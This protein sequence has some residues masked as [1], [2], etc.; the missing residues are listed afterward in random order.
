M[1]EYRGKTPLM[2]KRNWIWILT[3]LILL[4]LVACSKKQAE[5]TPATGSTTTAPTPIDP[6]TVGEVTGK[7]ALANAVR[8]FREG[9]RATWGVN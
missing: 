4:G 7:D 9:K 3:A 2:N 8:R 1:D 6:T 5:T